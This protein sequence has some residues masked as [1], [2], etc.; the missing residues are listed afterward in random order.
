[1]TYP[2]ATLPAPEDYWSLPEAEPRRA[3]RQIAG[4]ELDASLDHHVVEFSRGQPPALKISGA[5]GK[6]LL[7]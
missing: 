3:R 7:R 4:S 6:W 2:N 5:L 1:V